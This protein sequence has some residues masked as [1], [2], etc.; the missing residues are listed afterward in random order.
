MHIYAYISAIDVYRIKNC[1][2]QTCVLN[3]SIF[4]IPDIFRNHL[5]VP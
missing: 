1:L 5:G 3:L 4:I 2:L